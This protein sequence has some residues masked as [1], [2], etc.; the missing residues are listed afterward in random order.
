MWT[1]TR[2]LA[3]SLAA[4]ALALVPLAASAQDGSTWDEIEARGALRVGV[5]QAPPWFYKGPSDDEWTGLGAAMG[6]DMADKLGVAFEPVEVTWGTAVPALQADKIDLM[7]V[8]D[9][10]EERAQAVDFPENPLLYYSLAVLVDDDLSVEDWSDLN[11][12]GVKI[13][14]TQGTTMDGYVT[15]NLPDAEILRFPSNGEAVA[16]FQSRRVNAVSLFHPPLIAMRKQIGRG[17]IVV[18]NPPYQSASS[19]GVRKQDDQRFVD[20]VD[21]QIGEAYA[22]GQTQDWYEDFLVSFDVDPATVPAIQKAE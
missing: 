3:L 2:R 10:T 21:E 11:A 4:G 22:S 13:A 17:K 8:L 20:W 14:V 5:T 16:A 6:K 15:D 19:V 7:F 18:P 1:P 9:A 12:D